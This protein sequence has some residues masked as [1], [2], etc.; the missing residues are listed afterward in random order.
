M[1]TEV[2]IIGGG[3][4]G[5]TIARELRKKGVGRIAVVDRGPLGSEASWAAAGM[6]APNIEVDHVD[7]FHRF[8]TESLGLYPGFA[9][10]LKEETGIDIELDR[11]GTLYIAFT[12]PDVVELRAR[13]E[14]QKRADLEIEHL[15]AAEITSVEPLISRDVREGLVF[16]NDWQVENRK[17]LV[18]LRKSC[19]ITDVEILE[20][21]DVVELL[22]DGRRVIGVRTSARDIYSE[23]TVLAT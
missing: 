5:L 4:I 11:S 20:Q 2:L 14:R 3:V 13:W 1:N 19:E 18:A 23:T 10:S 21:T 9:E 8:C 17:L 12:E 16:P 6:L 7:F 22:T 15:S